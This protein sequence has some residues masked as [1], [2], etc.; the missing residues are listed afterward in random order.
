MREKI[1]LSWR[2]IKLRL[3]KSYIALASKLLVRE[4]FKSLTQQIE[5]LAHLN[6]YCGKIRATLFGRP[7]YDIQPCLSLEYFLNDR[8]SQ[9]NSI[10]ISSICSLIKIIKLFFLGKLIPSIVSELWS[11]RS[12]CTQRTNLGRPLF[13]LLMLSS[14]GS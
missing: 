3:I 10:S 12:A 13:L 1:S 4:T 8:E 7:P 9:Y 14:M 11:E 6:L 2:E 5:N